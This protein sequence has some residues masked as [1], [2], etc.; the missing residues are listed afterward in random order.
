M[1]ENTQPIE[2]PIRINRY[3]LLKGYCSRRKADTFIAQGQ[4]RLNGKVAVLGD[5]VNEGDTVEVGKLV[6]VTAKD[7]RYYALNKPVGIVSHDPKEG[8][9]GIEDIL[10]QD[11]SV[12]PIGRLDKA[13]YGL[14]LLSN[15]GR[16]VNRMLSPEFEHEKEYIV[17]VDKV[18]KE[19]VA[20]RMSKGMWLENFKAKPCIVEMIGPKT[21]RIVLTEGKKH[22]IRRM[23]VAS[24]YQVRELKRVRIMNIH[25]GSLKPGAYREL[26]ENELTALFKKLG[27][28]R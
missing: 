20:R 2:Y 15:D 17:S 18:L 26:T 6:T 11:R 12:V 1:N 5:K 24:G 19:S 10:P 27:M 8:E 25:L 4:V 9:Q 7:R 23:C 13:S 16:I 14:I 28:E 21:L 3:L 22:Q